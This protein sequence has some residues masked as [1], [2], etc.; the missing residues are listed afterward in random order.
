MLVPPP[1]TTELPRFSVGESW[2]P[3]DYLLGDANPQL[4]SATCLYFDGIDPDSP[5][6]PMLELAEQWFAKFELKPKVVLVGGDK[7]HLSSRYTIK[8]LRDATSNEKVRR[9]IDSVQLFPK[10]RTTIDDTHHPSV[11]FARSLRALSSAFF[12]VNALLGKETTREMLLEGERHFRSC[13]AYGFLFPAMFSPVSYY[14]GIAMHPSYRALGTWG[15]SELRRLSHWR[16]NSDIG[17]KQGNE[18]HFYRACDGY[19]RD[20]YPLMLLSRVHME[21]RIGKMT[22][23]NA[24]H[25]LSLGTVS[26]VGESY[27]WEVPSNK[28]TK[29]QRLLDEYAVAL[30]SRRFENGPE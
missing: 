25:H 17:I 16:D 11:Y 28:L 5:I 8:S 6:E 14:W 1:L 22:L 18:R 26:E 15:K 27:L 9:A 10:G 20:L 19:V 24:I 21:R 29:A 23:A 4:G 3:Y 2:A 13:A 30:S 12:S 7:E